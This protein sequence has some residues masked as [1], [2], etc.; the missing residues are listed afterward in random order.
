MV[1]LLLCHTATPL[2]AST[3]SIDTTWHN[4]NVTIGTTETCGITQLDG[5]PSG[6]HTTACIVP[7]EFNDSA[8]SSDTTSHPPT[9]NDT[10]T[11]SDTTPQIGCSQICK[12]AIALNTR[13]GQIYKPTCALRKAIREKIFRVRNTVEDTVASC[14][15]VTESTAWHNDSELS[16]TERGSV[17]STQNI[18][19]LDIVHH[20]A[21]F[22]G[23]VTS[24]QNI[25]WLDVVQ[26]F[27]RPTLTREDGC[28]DACASST[29]ISQWCRASSC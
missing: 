22:L 25:E 28:C 7:P 29:T 21:E 26:H 1:T 12:S 18:E 10:A 16:T 3:T 6:I 17:A 9:F 24:T 11:S 14:T 15:T 2:A 8:T 27:P 20:A 23:S 5:A 19:W 13:F 4:S